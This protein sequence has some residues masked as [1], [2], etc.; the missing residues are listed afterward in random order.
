MKIY[1]TILLSS[2]ILFMT[3][4][5]TLFTGTEDRITFNSTPSG[6]TIYIDG[7]EQCKTPCSIK[8]NRSINDTD[9][10]FKLDG[11]ETRLI[12][13]SK[14]LNV[15]SIINLGNLFGWAIDALSG[16]L[17]KYDRKTYDITLED[18]RT[19]MIKPTRINID[20]KN[21]IVELYVTEN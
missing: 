18:K 4:C 9:V 14:E 2:T 6:A 11:Y 21:N 20:T 10:E 3:S 13:L 16:A 19:S 17:M 1:S 12:T 8:V 5:A 15:V 7:V